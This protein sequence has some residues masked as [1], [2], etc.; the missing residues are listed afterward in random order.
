MCQQRRKDAF[1]RLRAAATDS[2]PTDRLWKVQGGFVACQLPNAY[3]CSW[4]LPAWRPG[5]R[6]AA[7]PAGPTRAWCSTY[8]TRSSAATSR[9]KPARR[10]IPRSRWWRPS[11]ASRPAS[12]KGAKNRSCDFAYVISSPELRMKI[13][14]YLPNTTLES[15]LA[16]DQIEV[17]DTTENSSTTADEAHVAYKVLTLGTSK[18]L[19]S[20]KTEADKYKRIVPKA[21]VLASGTTNREHG[22]FF[23]LRAVEAG[24]ARGRQGVHVSGRSA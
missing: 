2:P 4:V 23:K 9:P 18:N 22:V 11:F 19:S 17:A 10:P 20:K 6:W 3:G 7:G 15:T 12:L 1:G 5:W 8:P 24:I 16:E 14:D 21:L 13:Q